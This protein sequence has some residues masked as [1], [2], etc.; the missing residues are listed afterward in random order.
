MRSAGT[1]RPASQAD[2]ITGNQIT[3][4]NFHELAI[5]PNEGGGAGHLLQGVQSLLGFA[6]LHNADKRI[7]QNDG[8]DNGGVAGLSQ[9][10]GNGRGY[11]QHKNQWVV[12][13]L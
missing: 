2:D 9:Q 10:D 8:Q 3:G 11:K 7:Y 13:L 6:L 5:F 1:C 12:Q 4:R